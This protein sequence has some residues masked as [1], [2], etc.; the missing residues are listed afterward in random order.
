[1]AQRTGNSCHCGRGVEP[2]QN[3]IPYGKQS[4][5]EDD[6]EAV[7]DVLRSAFL[8]TGPLVEKFEKAFA[9]TVNADHAVS[10]SSGTAALHLA[11]IAAGLGPGTCAIVPAI[12]FVATANAP[13]FSGAD[14]VFSDVDPATGLMTADSL[15]EALEC[16]PPNLRAAAVFPVHL[17]G[18]TADPA[19]IREVANQH[20][21]IVVEDSCHALGTSYDVENERHLVGSCAHADMSIFSFHPVKTITQG[22]GGMVTTRRDDFA[23]KARLARNHGIVRDSEC[24]SNREEAYDSA[25]NIN[26]W[27]YEMQTLGLN[28]RQTEI[29][30]ALGLSQ[31]ARLSQFMSRRQE[32]AQRYDE[33]LEPLGPLVQ[34]I[35]STWSSPC[36]H[37]YAVLVDFDSAS[38][39][40]SEVMQD[41][42]RNGIRTQVHYIPVNRQPYYRRL[43]PDHPPLPG[44]DAYYRHCLS[45]P[46]FYE[47]T[48]DA[49]EHVVAELAR[50][51]T[52]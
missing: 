21:L 13:R 20:D 39:R 2:D 26:P 22:E 29:G 23:V 19:G 43:Y 27:Y 16:V 24:F 46:F 1:M 15:A 36:L 48:N 4:I 50:A 42:E 7:A 17:N 45:L 18:N 44:A 37:L 8:T 9:A 35:K 47:L 14:I 31:L 34:P 6:I 33:L 32:L 3:L 12:T 30:S 5:A 28:Y 38:K 49:Q 40:R 41:L 10:C 52:G 11:S 25:G 51:L